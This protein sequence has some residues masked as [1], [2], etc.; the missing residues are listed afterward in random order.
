MLATALPAH[1]QVAVMH[2]G[3]APLTKDQVANIYLGRSA[4]LTPLD[5]PEGNATRDSFY[6]KAA[7][8]EPAQV[9]STWARIVFTGKGQPPKELPDAAAVKKA[10][11]ADHKAIGYIDKSAVDGSVKVVLSLD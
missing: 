10:V 9:K 5:L 11:N 7:E 3:A 8:R 4:E 1:A 2:A 6:R